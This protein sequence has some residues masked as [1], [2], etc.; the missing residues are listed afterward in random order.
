MKTTKE[1]REN[2]F[3]NF[4]DTF[5]SDWKEVCDDLESTEKENARLHRIIAKELSEND[6]LGAEYTYVLSLKSELS[7]YREA[8][9]V[10][11]HYLNAMKGGIM[12]DGSH[13]GIPTMLN[14]ERCLEE[15]DRILNFKQEEKN[16]ERK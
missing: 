11:R 7:R 16:N 9:R 4:T 1:M 8:V 12:L 13:V 3:V 6:D 14:A 2:W 5:A 10:M 15:A